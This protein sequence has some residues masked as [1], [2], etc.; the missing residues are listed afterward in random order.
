MEI[1]KKLG[2]LPIRVAFIDQESEWESTIEIIRSMMYHKDVIPLWYQIPFKLNNSA[3]FFNEWLY[4]WDPEQ[5]DKWQRKKEDIAI[6]ENTYGE[7]LFLRLFEAIMAKDFKN[8]KVGS[9]SGV[10]AEES[11]KRLVGLTSSI[12]YKWITWG[13]K[14]HNPNHVNFYPIYDWSYT[15]IWKYINDNNLPYNRIYDQQYKYGLNIH[16]MRVS[17][18]HHETA[19]RSLFYMQEA[20]PET[21][22]KLINRLT[23]INTAKHLG[24]D[25]FY[26][27]NLPFMF[28]SWKE[29]RDY[30]LE[31]LIDEKYKNIF[32][33]W[34]KALD[35]EFEGTEPLVSHRLP[36]YDNMVREQI[37]SMICN[38]FECTKLKNLHQRNSTKETRAV[39]HMRE[40]KYGKSQKNN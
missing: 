26:I 23:G 9:I 1:A 11:P 17:S 34:F 32:R 38:D 18:L 3:S 20:E 22:N 19:L 13:R 21:F 14:Y 30:L 16:Q 24:F 2:K 8:D 5:K 27:K 36:K 4:C 12:T 28:T 29:Y 25:D 35:M 15:D 39:R 7:D 6:K 40:D 37:N 10:R 33:K 31:H